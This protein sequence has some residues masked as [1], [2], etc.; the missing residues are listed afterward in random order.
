LV[1]LPWFLSRVHNSHSFVYVKTTL[2]IP[3]TVVLIL[4]N[5]NTYMCRHCSF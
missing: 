4:A 5:G 1:S 3:L 2:H